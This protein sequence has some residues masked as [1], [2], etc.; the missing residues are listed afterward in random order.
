MHVSL[1][2]LLITA[3][4]SLAACGFQLRGEV[5]LASNLQRVYVTSSDTYGPLKHNVDLALAKSPTVQKCIVLNRCNTAV[6]MK[7]GRSGVKLRQSGEIRIIL[8]GQRRGL[9]C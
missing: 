5:K 9:I 4:L 8:C 6:E 2:C 3:A 1:R 7:A